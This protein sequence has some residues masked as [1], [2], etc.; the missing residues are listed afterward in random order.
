MPHAEDRVDAPSAAYREMWKDWELIRDLRGGTRAM[1]EAG[2][3]WLPLEPKEQPSSHQL[4]LDR[5][6]LFG[7]LNDAI[8]KLVAKPYS[9]PITVKG[10]ETLPEPLQPMV[11]RPTVDREQD[12]TDLGRTAFADAITWGLTHVLVDSP[13]QPE[14]GFSRGEQREQDIRPH[15][16]P[17]SPLDLIGWKTRRTAAGS[18]ELQ[19]IRYVRM[20]TESTGRFSER[21]VKHVRVMT[22]PTTV[23]LQTDDDGGF[24]EIEMP[25]TFEVWRIDPDTNDE[26]LI[27]GGLH[28]F[29]GIPLVTLYTGRTGFMTAKPPLLDL[30]WL[31]LAHWQTTADKRNA[32]RVA[33]YS[34]IHESGVTT[35]EKDEALLIGPTTLV[36]R[37]DPRSKMSFV[38][39]DGR[40]IQAGTDE[41]RALEGHMQI[42]GMMPMFSKSGDQTATGRAIDEGQSISDVLCWVRTEEAFIRE[43]YGTA[44]RWVD[45]EAELSEEFQIDVFSDFGIGLR[46]SEEVQNLI[47]LGVAGKITDRLLL[48]EMKRRA[49][50][51]EDVDVDD[52]LAALAEQ[53]SGLKDMG[54][55]VLTTGETNEHAHTYTAGDT[56][57][58]AMDGHVHQINPDGSIAESGDSKH[59]HTADPK[60]ADAGPEG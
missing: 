56:Q 41:Q 32:L 29:P 51:S 21:R 36:R 38:N 5:A 16:T 44:L 24:I 58:G 57:T 39:S 14:A 28:T 35:N 59:T 12:L 50:L 42:L 2:Q 13:P 27:D 23:Q 15:V 31:N 3:R 54:G 9:K 53:T 8:R 37:Q 7:G 17:I 47:S 20:V 25:G 45:P 60:A 52:E 55:A 48:V 49:V 33:L 10:E 19:E 40:N 34:L 26:Q 6:I 30:A 18:E 43:I 46:A 22:A 4:R 11:S 1:R